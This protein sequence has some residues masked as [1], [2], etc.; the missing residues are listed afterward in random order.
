M[1]EPAVLAR[2]YQVDWIREMVAYHLEHQWPLT[3]AGWD[4]I[5]NAEVTDALVEEDPESWEPDDSLKL[6]R[7]PEP[8]TAIRLAREC[9]VP[10]VL[11]LAFLHLLRQP[12]EIDRDDRGDLHATVWQEPERALVGAADLNRLALARERMGK[13]FS[14]RPKAWQDCESDMRAQ[15][16]TTRLRTWLIIATNVTRDGN[17]LDASQ[18]VL[19]NG[20]M[21]F[22][23]CPLCSM[24]ARD[25]IRLMR[26]QFFGQLGTFFQL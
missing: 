15:C 20:M 7:L 11:P 13:W 10:V 22:G 25:E 19:Q 26:E 23:I 8:V 21:R 3:L 16:E 1:F 18:W 5:A 14:S 9:D 24:R 6:H 2:K 12:L 4:R 17:V